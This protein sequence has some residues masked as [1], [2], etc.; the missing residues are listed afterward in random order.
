MEHKC[1]DVG[2]GLGDAKIAYV[3]YL[4]SFVTLNLFNTEESKNSRDRDEK[5]HLQSPSLFPQ[6]SV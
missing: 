4:F 5:E 1:G 2:G 6:R 3:Q